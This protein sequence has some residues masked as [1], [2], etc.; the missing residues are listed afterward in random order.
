MEKDKF[1]IIVKDKAK[2][3][4]PGGMIE[5]PFYNISS[6]FY[7][8]YCPQPGKGLGKSPLFPEH[9]PIY[10]ALT[11]MLAKRLGLSVPQVFVMENRPNERKK[12]PVFKYEIKNNKFNANM[13]FYFISKIESELDLTA[14]NKKFL[15][16]A[17]DEHKI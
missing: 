6:S 12:D 13:P 14:T 11:V 3:G 4:N 17:I 2:G 9:Q 7:F 15:S 10:E 16:S 8:K 1:E 5:I